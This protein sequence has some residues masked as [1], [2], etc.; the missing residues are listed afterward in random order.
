MLSSYYTDIYEYLLKSFFNHGKLYLKKF[1][2]YV[3]IYF[4]WWFCFFRIWFINNKI[5]KNI[6]FNTEYLWTNFRENEKKIIFLI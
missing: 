3:I 2:N 1:L 5:N 4:I 6:Y